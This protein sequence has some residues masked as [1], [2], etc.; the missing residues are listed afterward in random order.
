MHRVSS[1]RLGWILFR[2][3]ASHL[4][5]RPGDPAQRR[6]EVR[7]VD[8]GEEQADHPEQVVVREQ[9]QQ[10]QHGH[11]FKLELLRLVGHPLRQRVQVQIEIADQENGADQDN[12]DDDHQNVG[13]TWGGDESRQ[14][15]RR[16]GVNRLAQ[17]NPPFM[18]GLTRWVGRLGSIFTQCENLASDKVQPARVVWLEDEYGRSYHGHLSANQQ[19]QPANT[20]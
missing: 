16:A 4:L 17:G 6:A 1:G 12:A 2:W 7:Q 9:R 3:N 13:V 8:H 15:M 10:T 5:D 14:M 20:S 18:T 19:G 11:D